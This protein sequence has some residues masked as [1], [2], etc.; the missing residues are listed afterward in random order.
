MVLE[1]PAITRGSLPSVLRC[2]AATTDL[3]PGA[4]LLGQRGFFASFAGLVEERADLPAVI[5]AFDERVLLC[6]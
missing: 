4:D 5:Q 6:T 3:A 1:E 2:L